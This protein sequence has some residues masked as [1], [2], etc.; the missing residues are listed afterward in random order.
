MHGRWNSFYFCK[1]TNAEDPE[2]IKKHD[3]ILRE[4][5]TLNCKAKTCN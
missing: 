5:L 1:F 4:E 2:V 3:A